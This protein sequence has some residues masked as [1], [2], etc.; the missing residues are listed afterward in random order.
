MGKNKGAYHLFRS[1][2]DSLNRE[3]PTAHVKKILQVRTEEVND[4][5]IVQSLLAE[6]VNLRYAGCKAEDVDERRGLRQCPQSES[7]G[8]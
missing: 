3:F 7:Q 5:N 6:V 8:G 4:E 2:A 1:H